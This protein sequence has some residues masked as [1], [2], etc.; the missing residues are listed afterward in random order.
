MF[1]AG[2]PVS[3]ALVG[4]AA[5]IGLRF[6]PPNF[7]YA[8][9]PSALVMLWACFDHGI[10][11]WKV[12]LAGDS[13]ALPEAHLSSSFL[14]LLTLNAFNMLLPSASSGAVL[15][16]IYAQGVGARR[17]L[18]LAR[19]WPRW[20]QRWL[21][22]LL[23]A[24][25]GRAAS[26]DAG[27]FRLPQPS[28]SPRSARRDRRTPLCAPCPIARGSPQSA[29]GPCFLPPPEL[30]ASV[31]VLKA[32]AAQWLWRIAG[33]VF[34]VLLLFVLCAIPPLPD[35][36]GGFFSARPA[37]SAVVAAGLA[38]AVWRVVSL[39]APPGARSRGA[40]VL[41]CAATTH[42]RCCSAVRWLRIVVPSYS[43]RGGRP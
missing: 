29:D 34:S 12:L 43:R 19:E 30:P 42:A 27:Y 18:V 11:N 21:V 28:I 33:P 25:L 15:Q 4:L 20:C 39:R 10:Y 16:P 5:G 24:P 38:F 31:Q 35:G 2:H 41:P 13:D 6:L 22:A 23:R 37:R 26:D 32:Y 8:W 40:E 9:I 7:L 14:H 17:D 3:T 1:F 36:C